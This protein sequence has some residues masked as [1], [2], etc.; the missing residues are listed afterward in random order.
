MTQQPLFCDDF[1]EALKTIGQAFGGSKKMGGYLWPD[2]PVDKAAQLWA[3]CLNRSRPEKLDPEQVLAVL[4]I[5]RQIGCHAGAHFL[6]EQCGYKYEPVEPEEE[7]AKLMRDFVNAKDD[8]ARL[9]SK[10]EN[11]T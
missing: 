5:G 11:L 3:D 2:K 10:L 8:L 6:A 4:K 7:K 1:Y 9:L